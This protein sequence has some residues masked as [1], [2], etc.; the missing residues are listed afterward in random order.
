MKIEILGTGCPKCK[1]VFQNAEEAVKNLNLDAE[2]E[3]VE[4]IQKIMDAGVMMTP[5]IV[6]DS[7]V[8][9]AGKVLSVDEIKKILA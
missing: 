7:E 5:A 3:K 9:S 8:K 1:R 4:D 6:V 2:I